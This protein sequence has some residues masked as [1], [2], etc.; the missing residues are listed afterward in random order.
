VRR[1]EAVTGQGALDWVA[2]SDQ[3]LRE[4]AAIVKANRDDVEDKVRQLASAA[5]SS[6]RKLRR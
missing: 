2:K 6:R 5:A 3:V 4:L 1:I